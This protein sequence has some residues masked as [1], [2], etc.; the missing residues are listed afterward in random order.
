MSQPPTANSPHI[1]IGPTSN[2]VISD[3][4]NQSQF[5]R[6]LLLG[7][8]KPTLLPS[9]ARHDAAGVEANQIKSVRSECNRLPTLGLFGREA[10]SDH[11]ACSNEHVGGDREDHA[12]E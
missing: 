8:N 12:C 7:R 4:K 11:S 3:R 10:R 1:A 2:S 9:A 6:W 5:F